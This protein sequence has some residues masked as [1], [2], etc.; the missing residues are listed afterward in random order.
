MAQGDIKVK[1]K[2]VS[3]N[4]TLKLVW[5]VNW[6]T[7]DEQNWWNLRLDAITGKLADENNWITE[8]QSTNLSNTENQSTNLINPG[9]GEGSGEGKSSAK[10]KVLARPVESPSHGNMVLLNDPSDSL[11]SPL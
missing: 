8:C 3:V 2:W 7:K 11:S 6:I 5:N 1:L 4:Q 9:T 10:Y